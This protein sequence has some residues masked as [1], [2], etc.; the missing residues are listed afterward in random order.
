MKFVLG[1][2]IQMRSFSLVIFRIPVTDE[3]KILEKREDSI[4]LY[5]IE[6]IE[7]KKSLKLHYGSLRSEP[8]LHEIQLELSNFNIHITCLPGLILSAYILIHYTRLR[9]LVLCL[10][11]HNDGGTFHKSLHKFHIALHFQKL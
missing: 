11:L 6:T 10:C 1:G 7:M 8:H 3:R 4:M 2:V 9:A 5:T